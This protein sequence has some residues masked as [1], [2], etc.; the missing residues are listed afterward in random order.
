MSLTQYLFKSFPFQVAVGAWSNSSKCANFTPD[1][2]VLE[3]RGELQEYF[4]KRV[5]QIVHDHDLDLGGWEDGFMDGNAAYDREEL[6]NTEVYA[7]AWNNIWEL[8]GKSDAYILAND[9]YKVRFFGLVC[10][11][12]IF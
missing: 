8:N 4:I 6:P 2:D 1:G 9:D 10:R 12:G 3:G 7:Y 11:M 5:A